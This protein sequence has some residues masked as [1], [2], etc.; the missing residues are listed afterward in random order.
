MSSLELMNHLS[1]VRLGVDMGFIDGLTP[2]TLNEL[3]IFTQ[4]AHMQKLDQRLEDSHQRD[5][6]R[7]EMIR[8]KIH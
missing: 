6:M 4:P 7:A 1:M 2:E 5:V 8:Q 3:M